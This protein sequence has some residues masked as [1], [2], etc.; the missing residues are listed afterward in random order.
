M[1]NWVVVGLGLVI[2]AFG[3][4]LFRASE[5]F[6]SMQR[7]AAKS[8]RYPEAMQRRFT[9]GLTRVAGVGFAVMGVLWILGGAFLGD[10]M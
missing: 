9:P 10:K 2:V 1:T 8:M 5:Q 3:V 6:S 4:V 7:R